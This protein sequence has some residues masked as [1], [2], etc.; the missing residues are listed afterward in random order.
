MRLFDSLTQEY[1]DLVPLTQGKVGLYTCGPTVY[2]R[3]HVGNFRTYL[4]QDFLKRYLLWTGL[5]VSHVMNVTDVGH[6]TDDGD[7]GEDKVEKASALKGT[8]ARDLARIYTD[9]FLQDSAHLNIIPPTVLCRATDHITEQIEQIRLIFN[10]GFAYTIEGD[11]LYFD[12]SKL[13]HYGFGPKKQQVIDHVLGHRVETRN[14]RNPADFA[15]WKFS[16]ADKQRQM[17]W[18]SPWGRGFPGWHIE[19]SA[20]ATRYLGERFDIHA[21]GM[22][23]IPVHH[24]NELAQHNAAFGKRDMAGIWVHSEFLTFEEGRKMSKSNGGI[25]SLDDLKDR[26]FDALDFRYLA[27]QAHYR[28]QLRFSWEALEASRTARQ[29]LKGLIAGPEEESSSASVDMSYLSRLQNALADDLNTP[30]AL[31]LLWELLRDRMI[32]TAVKRE[33]ALKFDKVLGLELEQQPQEIR[34][35]ALADQIEALLQQ[36]AEARQNRDWEKADDL[37]KQLRALGHTVKDGS[38]KR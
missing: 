32:S 2:G 5:E 18:E 36:R 31:A 15:L 20:M 23:H 3:A 29:R 8:S 12:T 27:L 30:V 26:G 21:G 37:R 11:G 28:S 24:T 33:T 16:P 6:L 35:P 13:D 14:K 17:E 7:Q 34:D 1:K 10:N 25:L 9:L 19:C 22:D 4:S 38:V